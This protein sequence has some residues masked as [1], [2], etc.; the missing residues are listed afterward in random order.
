MTKD[1][2]RWRQRQR[3]QKTRQLQEIARG[4]VDLPF[5]ALVL[6]LTVIGLIMLFSASFPSALDEH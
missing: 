2:K 1:E 5:L 6:V 3:R 4:P